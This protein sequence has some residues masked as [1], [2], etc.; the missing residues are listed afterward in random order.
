LHRNWLINSL[1]V[2][3]ESHNIISIQVFVLSKLR[4]IPD[5][6]K[7]WEIEM[8]F[9]DTPITCWTILNCIGWM[10]TK[11]NVKKASIDDSAIINQWGQK[12]PLFVV[13]FLYPVVNCIVFYYSLDVKVSVLASSAVDRGIEP[14]VGQTKDYK[15]G[16]CCF[17]AKRAA[18]RRKSKDWLARNQNNVSEW[19]RH[20]YPWTVASVR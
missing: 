18:L 5:L 12:Q 8:H 4:F 17:S 11:K 10:L 9:L 3:L 2:K 19:G 20:V 6:K 15:I 16:I 13:V 14:L 7:N 1:R